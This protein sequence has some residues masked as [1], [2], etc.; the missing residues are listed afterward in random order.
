MDPMQYVGRSV[1]QTERFIK[2]VVEPLR[3]QYGEAIAKLES[4]GPKV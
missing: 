1:Q 3:K 4:S 2:E